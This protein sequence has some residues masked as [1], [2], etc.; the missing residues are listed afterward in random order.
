MAAKDVKAAK[1]YA[2]ALFNSLEP[3]ALEGVREGLNAIS[4]VWQNVPALK[5][6]LLNPATPTREKIAVAQDLA[7]ASSS[8][9]EKLKNFCTIIAENSRFDLLPEIAKVFSDL[10]DTMKQVSRL[11]V[12]SAFPLQ[13]T[14]QEQILSE[15]RKS[16]GSLAAIQW[17]V[18]PELLG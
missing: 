8:I 10:V 2:K 7:K 13:N 4:S 9:E 14:E 1:K 11:E 5:A 17:S 18:D 15:V 6:A 16:A 3:D 12:I